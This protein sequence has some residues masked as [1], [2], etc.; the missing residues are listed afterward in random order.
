LVTE[1]GFD[2]EG[3]IKILGIMSNRLHRAESLICVILPV[4]FIPELDE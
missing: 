3:T 2:D 4:I 1:E